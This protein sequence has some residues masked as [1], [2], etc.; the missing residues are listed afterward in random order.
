MA[1][2]DEFFAQHYRRVVAALDVAL[3][4]RSLA[5]DATQEAFL[6]ALRRWRSV[7]HLD[8]PATWVYV[9]AMREARR[10]LN[11]RR[12]QPSE[13]EKTDAIDIAVEVAEGL[14]L[15]E[16]LAALPPRQRQAVTLRFLADLP[17][18]DIA[19]AMGCRPG[20]VKSTLHAALANLRVEL[21]DNEGEP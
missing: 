20:T 17:V 7:A 16:A 11:R 14:P 18:A 1:E 8:R 15:R 13:A 3:L 21:D 6:R 4:D 5:E 12:H 10:Q 19:R 9:V 2:F